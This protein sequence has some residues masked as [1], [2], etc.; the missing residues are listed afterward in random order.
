M[1][2]TLEVI[3]TGLEKFADDLVIFAE[4]I[5]GKFQAKSK[6]AVIA[7][8][9]EELMQPLHQISASCAS[10]LDYFLE[11]DVVLEALDAWSMQ[12]DGQMPSTGQ[13]IEAAIYYAEYD[14][15]LPLTP[16]I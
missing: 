8:S 9:D 16:E 14:A 6:A 12:R 1:S 4:R 7:L 11:I 15:Y 5:D 13:T 10:G 3:L 2:T